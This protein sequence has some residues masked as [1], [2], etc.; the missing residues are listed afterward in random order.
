MAIQHMIIMFATS[1]FGWIG[2]ILSGLNRAYPFMLNIL[3]LAAGIA[4][5][6][7]YYSRNAET[8]APAPAGTG[9]TTET[10]E[11]GTGSSD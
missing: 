9:E 11:D 5:T 1:P 10:G 3:L 4:V 8:L 6:L 2:G 7:L